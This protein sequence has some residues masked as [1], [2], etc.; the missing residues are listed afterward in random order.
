MKIM[1]VEV[2]SIT[3]GHN[4]IFGEYI[5]NS[6]IGKIK[7]KIL[8][9]YTKGWFKESRD[10]P[11]IGNIFPTKTLCFYEG[12]PKEWKYKIG[13]IIELS[14]E[15]MTESN[16]EEMNSFTNQLNDLKK[17]KGWFASIWG[18]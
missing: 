18:G 6:I 11:I 9:Q 12:D 2:K 16:Q 14:N 3:T 7:F 1:K 4:V 5:E 13:D 8:A 17:R 15:H 10:I